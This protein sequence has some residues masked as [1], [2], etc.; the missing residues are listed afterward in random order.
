MERIEAVL[1]LPL[2]FQFAQQQKINA[3][4][5]ELRG[6]LQTGTSSEMSLNSIHVLLSDPSGHERLKRLDRES[7]TAVR[8]EIS[9]ALDSAP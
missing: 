3:A 9:G 4:Y 7:D 1:G 2:Y 8:A 6:Y 5:L